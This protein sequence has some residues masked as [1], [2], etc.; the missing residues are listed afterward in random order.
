MLDNL[1]LVLQD[2]QNLIAPGAFVVL[3]GI[4]WR[5]RGGWLKMP[6]TL[7]GRMV[8]TILMALGAAALS[9][10][11]WMLLAGPA[12]YLGMIM[13]WAQ[14]MDMGRVEDN[15]DFVGLSGRGMLLTLPLG[16][17]MYA[18]GY[19][20]IPLVG[21]VLMGTVYWVSWHIR[22]DT[23]GGEVGTGMLLG[24]LVIAG[25]QLGL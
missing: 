18:L 24:A 11:L 16:L 1:L 7:L 13:P 19:G 5:I 22:L 14:W 9:G 25:L 21:G 4:A 12:V 17:L 2:N 15:D 10:N 23:E 3:M 8:P 6:S 20:I